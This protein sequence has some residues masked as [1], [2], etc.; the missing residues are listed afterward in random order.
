MDVQQK[1]STARKKN[2]VGS[3][4]LPLSII[5]K[6]IKHSIVSPVFR[7]IVSDHSQEDV[8]HLWMTDLSNEVG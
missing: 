3:S 8:N 6:D 1:K 7:L 5:P 4:E 2:A